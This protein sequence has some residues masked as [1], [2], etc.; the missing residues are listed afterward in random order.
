MAVS[1]G[2][3]SAIALHLLRTSCPSKP[4]TAVFMNNW[5]ASDQEE[6]ACTL[7]ADY[8]SAR[9]AC[10]QLG[11]PLRRLSF[12]REYWC[13]V[14]QRSIEAYN[15]GMETPN[16][17]VLCNREIKFGV[18]LEWARS[19]GYDTLATGHYA[20]ICYLK[21][22][23]RTVLMQAKDKRKDQTYFLSQIRCNPS[24]LMFPL[25]DHCKSQVR[26]I[27][28]SL[29]MDWLLQRP[30]SMGI[31]FVGQ[32][33]KFSSFL[34]QYLEP[35][36]GGDFIDL[37]TG[38]VVGVH[39]GLPYYTIGQAAKLPSQLH[40]YYVARKDGQSNVIFL[41][42]NRLHPVLNPTKLKVADW[43]LFID[44][45][46]P[47]GDI[48]CSIRSEDKDGTRVKQIGE[49]HIELDAPIYAPAPGQ[50]AVLYQEHADGHRICLGSA[51]IVSE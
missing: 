23:G 11:V 6:I 3:D 39:V 36:T 16:P 20:K 41:V 2:V 22:M 34:Q 48:F 7:D 40:K 38:K 14:F 37:E 17:D 10:H 47:V 32:A 27:A 15:G 13:S 29:G 30:E 42:S 51:K 50:Y 18:L 26:G 46:L 44:A 4:V 21:D 9:R 28:H 35:G 25:G 33:K 1:G 5:D 49:S 8:D 31:C 19:N 24:R 43:N 12:R 45:P